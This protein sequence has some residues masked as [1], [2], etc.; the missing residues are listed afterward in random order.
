MSIWLVIA[1]ISIAAGLW[2]AWPYLRAR[3][4]EMSGA[5]GAISIYRDQLDEIDRDHNQGLINKA[6]AE[7]AKQEVERRALHAARNLDSGM[8]SS[9]RSVATAALV[10]VMGV[11]SAVGLYAWLG[12]PGLSDAPL[13]ERRAEALT[14]RAEAGD[15]TS[16]IQLLIERTQ[17][18]PE[19]FSDW[20]M[21]AQAYK[22]VGDQASAADAF[23]NA[24]ALAEDRPAVLSSYAEALTLAN[25]N[26]VPSAARVIFEQLAKETGEPRAMYYVGLS[27]A[28]SQ[29]FQG[30]I[31][32]W[33]ELARVSAPEAPWMPTV[34]R[35][36][37]NMA[38]ILKQDLTLYLPD[39]T[40]TEIASAG[41]DIAA[42]RSGPEMI[43]L[44]QSA[45]ALD[46]MDYQSWLDLVVAK[47]EAGDN[48]GA[49]QTISDARQQ[50]AAAPFLMQKFAETERA[51]GLDMLDRPR[52]PSAADIA[53]ASEMSQ[54]ERDDMIEGMVAGLAA[55]L[56]E[57]PNDPNGWVML[58]R[59]YATLG[60]REQA[61]Q[62]LVRARDVFAD[63]AQVLGEISS[64]VSDLSL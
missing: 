41:G 33:A 1:L 9:N 52:G 45:V 62:A 44:L 12:Q 2:M 47:A 25:G 27:R 56:D 28:Q 57:T 60:R 3:T 37:T 50:F 26:K 11:V 13:A 24:A 40:S 42:S 7:A 23:K 17:D 16:R 8:S 10:T 5:E 55:R 51:L 34:R 19:S 4:M 54:E 59:S 14:Q 15:I 48:E 21:L 22:S 18:D 36:I 63:N 31:D 58:I 20:W 43:A 46:P 38:R 35:D 61:K 53:A 29:N 39:A 30:A 32:V 6:E 49:M 64:S